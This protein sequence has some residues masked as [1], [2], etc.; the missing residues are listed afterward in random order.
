MRRQH[1]RRA[2]RWFC[3]LL[4]SQVPALQ[5]PSAQPT[6]AVKTGLGCLPRQ[7][8]PQFARQGGGRAAGRR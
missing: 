3:W 7:L 5:A 6:R 1:L 8:Q 4:C 2:L